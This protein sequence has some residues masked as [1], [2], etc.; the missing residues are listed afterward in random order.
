MNWA[1]AQDCQVSS[2]LAWLIMTS[3]M[4]VTL[5]EE[6][7]WA[8]GGGSEEEADTGAKSKRITSALNRSS[9]SLV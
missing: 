9:I 3:D 7:L 5:G 6:G 1:L 4:K 8:G 2:T